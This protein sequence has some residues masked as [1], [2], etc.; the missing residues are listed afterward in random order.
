MRKLRI[1][2]KRSPKQVFPE[3]KYI[4]EHAFTIGGV[5]YYRHNDVF[6]LPYERGMMALSIYEECRMGISHEYLEL[7]TKAIENILKAT[8]INVYHINTLNEQL[9][10]RM[11]FSADADLLYKLASV[12]FFDKNENPNMYEADYC[13]KKIDHWKKYKDVVDFFLQMPVRELIPYLNSSGDDLRKSF[14]AVTEISRQ[15]LDNLQD[16]TSKTS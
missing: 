14:R 4:I 2:G 5:D 10:E 9:K 1:W 12:V 8:K 6:S 7:H 15:H 3:S 13:Q 16:I 11:G